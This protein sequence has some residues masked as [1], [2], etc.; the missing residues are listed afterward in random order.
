M[1][2]TKSTEGKNSLEV[3]VHGQKLRWQV[4]VQ[5]L[6]CRWQLLISCIR[7]VKFSVSSGDEDIFLRHRAGGIFPIDVNAIQSATPS[8]HGQQ[9]AAKARRYSSLAAISLKRPLPQP[10]M[11]SSTFSSG[12][13][14]PQINNLSQTFLII[15]T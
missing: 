3:N 12:F 15:N 1:I 6:H 2:F 9:S 13:C 4:S 14:F 7:S 8:P 11:E 5:L 10:P